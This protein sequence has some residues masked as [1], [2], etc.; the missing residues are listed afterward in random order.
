MRHLRCTRRAPGCSSCGTGIRYWNIGMGF[1]ACILECD[2]RLVLL[3]RSVYW[4]SHGL[5]I[6][7]SYKPDPPN[8][9]GLPYRATKRETQFLHTRTI[10]RYL[11]KLCMTNEPCCLPDNCLPDTTQLIYDSWQLPTCSSLAQTD[12]I[13]TVWNK[14]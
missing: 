9:R 12:A 7:R 8:G 10:Q 1:P 4:C 6:E 5:Q 3:I 11:H 13:S 14:A 2:V